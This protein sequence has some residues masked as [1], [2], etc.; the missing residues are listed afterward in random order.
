MDVTLT[1]TGLGVVGDM[2]WGTHFCL[3]YQTK[4]DLLETLSS[5]FRTGLD[6][7]E[8][9]LWVLSK[10]QLTEAEARTWLRKTIPDADHQVAAGRM[11]LISHEDWFLPG[12]DFEIP[13]V[14]N[15]LE[16]R[17][18]K[19]LANG[20][21]GLRLNG[22]PAWIQ[23]RSM[24]DFEAF[25]HALDES[26]AGRRIIL[27]CNFPSATSSAGEMLGAA[28]THH[29]TVAVQEG[30]SEIVETIQA[31]MQ[32]PLTR[33]ELEV[34]TWVARGKSAWET[35]EILGISKRTVDEHVQTA[36]R[37]LGAANRTHSIALAL[38]RHIIEI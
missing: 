8:F 31:P 16:D 26:I 32:H 37:K 34:L 9:C 14:I 18:E 23:K 25:E 13:K 38:L 28:H 30:V 19:A 21:S 10:G 27:L 6:R 15:V 29:F 1:S 22:G 4:Q 3:F 5:Y 7:N 33:R 24:E 36:T 35:A 2:P 12:G 11:E 20:L 17:N